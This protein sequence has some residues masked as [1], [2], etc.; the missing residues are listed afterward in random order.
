MKKRDPSELHSTVSMAVVDALPV[1]FF[2]ASAVFIAMIYKDLL[3]C[4]GAA[5]CVLGGLGKVLWKLIKAIS[6][7]D[8]RILFTGLRV[9]MPAGFVLIIISLFTGRAD[10]SAVWESISG[11]PC[12]IFFAAGCV[13]MAAMTVLAF[14]ADPADHR[15]NWIEQTINSTAQLCF[16][17]GIIIIWYASDHYTADETAKAALAGNAAVIVSETEFGMAFDGPGDDTALV[18]YPGAK[19]EYTAYA[20][21]MLALAGDGTDCFL[22]RMPYNLAVFDMSAAEKVFESYDYDKWFIGG[23]SL[24]GAAASIYAAKRNDIS[25]EVLLGA[26]PTS[27]PQ[28]PTIII[29]G[30][31]DKV[32]NRKKLEKGLAMDNV[33][34][35]SIE[36]G[37]HAGF[38][39]YGVQSGDG[40]AFISPEEQRKA[41]EN[42]VLEFILSAE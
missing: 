42:K 35:S 34:G 37:N 23:H 38:G 39:C 27:V 25:G 21:L 33:T 32:I 26:Y 19:V 20:P 31:E 5:V 6:G 16:L 2:S 17:L 12:V 11:F 36:G 3:F 4:I 41:A 8:I 22:C 15:I 9:L 13:C 24:G 18:F 29:Y 40:E 7:K 10:M 28:C 1:I 14:T 30:S